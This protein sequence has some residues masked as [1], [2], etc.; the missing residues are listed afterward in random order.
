M[1]HV[2]AFAI[3]SVAATGTDGATNSAREWNWAPPYREADDCGPQALFALLRLEGK[4]VSVWDVKKLVQSKPGRG[5]S[6]E[7]LRQAAETL[8]CAVTVRF[9]NPRELCD[10][11]RPFILHGSTGIKK[12]HGV[13]VVVVDYDS[14]KKLYAMIN[15]TF[16]SFEWYPEDGVLVGF[17]GY[18][19]VPSRLGIGAWGRIAG[20]ATLLAGGASLLVSIGILLWGKKRHTAR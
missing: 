7:A 15:P 1:R 8:D 14:E 13:F 19:L 6:I 3:L 10:V 20:G 16:E 17:D 18:V 11:P 4:Q 12:K 5:A 2:L 9:V